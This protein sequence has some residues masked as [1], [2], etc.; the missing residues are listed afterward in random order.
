MDITPFMCRKMLLI[1]SKIMRWQIHII[2]QII[3]ITIHTTI[4]IIGMEIIRI[5]L[6]GIFIGDF[7]HIGTL[8]IGDFIRM[9]FITIGIIIMEVTAMGFMTVIM[10][11]ITEAAT[12]KAT[13]GLTVLHKEAPTAGF[14]VIRA[15]RPQRRPAE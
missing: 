6:T 10:Q 7:R 14:R 5:I 2:R 8:D 11:E 13:A 3:R 1:L 15:I 4:P 12:T 9:V